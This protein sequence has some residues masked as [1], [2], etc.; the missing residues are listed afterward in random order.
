MKD[1]N[2]NLASSDLPRYQCAN[3]KL[4]IVGRKAVKLHR[5]LTEIAKKLNKS[6]ARCRRV[7]KLTKVFRK[8]K[9]RLRLES[10]TRWSPFYL[11]LLST[12][13][14]YDKGAFDQNDSERRCP[15]SF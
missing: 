5:E 3:P 2:I 9:W 12:K 10:K 14:A 7:I 1:L 11:L 8:K 15:V 6:N 4:D 13:K